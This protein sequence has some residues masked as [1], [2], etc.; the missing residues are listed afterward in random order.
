MSLVKNFIMMAHYNQRINRQLMTLC[1]TLPEEKLKQQ[2]HSFFPNV[3]SYWNHILFG[4]LILLSR[5]ASLNV[6]GLSPEL[7]KAL[8]T[9]KAPTDIYSESI[10]ELAQLREQVDTLIL[11]Y[12][13]NLSEQNCSAILSYS[14][15][16]GEKMTKVVADVIQHLFNH[17]THHRGQL[18]CILSQLGLDYGCMD[19]P[20]IVSEGS[21][22]F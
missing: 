4:D 14:T 15:T 21:K 11:N 12:C 17:Q 19:L 13:S 5:M 16:E 3:L 6:A 22:A 8:P 7:F 20:V 18:T 1:L 10:V 9:P 2:T